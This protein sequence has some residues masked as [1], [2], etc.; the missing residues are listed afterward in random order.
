MH[1]AEPHKVIFI[2]VED[3]KGAKKNCR[4]IMDGEGCCI[5]QGKEKDIFDPVF[6]SV[7]WVGVLGGG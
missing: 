5:S 1:K 7:F 4:I 6:Y 3:G 2:A